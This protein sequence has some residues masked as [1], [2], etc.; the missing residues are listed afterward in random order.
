MDI[1]SDLL[2]HSANIPQHTVIMILSF[3]I[4][5]TII[6]IFRYFMGLK[7]FGLYPQLMII[8]TLYTFSIIQSSNELDF[9]RG[10]KIELLFL[11]ASIISISISKKLL[12]SLNFH[13]VPRKNLLLTIG[14][15]SVIAILFLANLSDK[16]GVLEVS[17]LGIFGILTVSEK[18]LN[19]SMKKGTRNAFK[20]M[21]YTLVPCIFIG[22]IITSSQ[23]E[24]FLLQ[25]S[26]I[27]IIA[28]LSN[29]LIAGYG[30]IRLSEIF[31]FKNINQN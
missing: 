27:V 21:I 20:H 1:F 31:R 16:K 17:F 26:W 8:Y 29:L 3:P 4:I 7:S 25:N 12:D 10:L 28:I 11:A 14:M 23:F 13:V 24:S 19:F 18:Y 22:F 6:A 5:S 15:I 30:G 2:I 9:L